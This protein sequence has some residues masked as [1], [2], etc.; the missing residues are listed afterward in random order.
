MDGNAG[1]CRGLLVTRCGDTGTATMQVIAI[2]RCAGNYFLVG[3][4]ICTS[5]PNSRTTPV[6]D[7][8]QEHWLGQHGRVTMVG[9]PRRLRSSRWCSLNDVV[10]PA[11]PVTADSPA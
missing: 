1:L 3:Y 7:R 8:V 10:A 11:T 2:L 9:S 4:A 5:S 6:W